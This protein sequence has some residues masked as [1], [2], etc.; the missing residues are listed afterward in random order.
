MHQIKKYANRKLYDTTDKQYISLDQLA[1]LIKSGEEVSIMDNQT[2]EDITAAVISQLLAREKKGAHEEVPSGILMQLLR[3]GRGTLT[4]YAKKYAGLF[5]NAVTLAEDEIDR[6]VGRLVNDREISEF[7]GSRLKK[8]ILGY[9]DNLRGWVTSNVDRRVNEVL[10]RMKLVT[11]DQL[12][13]LADRID[14]LE[15][16]VAALRAELART[17]AASAETEKAQASAG[18]RDPHSNPA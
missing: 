13:P 10:G 11:R 18:S 17:A 6:L 3:K 5:Q 7:E 15:S 1:D 14:A 4:D 12:R 8:E 16:T 9:A 2:G